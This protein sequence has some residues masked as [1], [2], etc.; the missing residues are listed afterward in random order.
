MLTTSH[1]PGG[2]EHSQGFQVG[3]SW[4][5]R[6]DLASQYIH[7]RQIIEITNT[8]SPPHLTTSSVKSW[9]QIL[10]ALSSRELA[11]ESA[12]RSSV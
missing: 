2:S 8:S 10:Q 11:R 5:S 6:S 4:P 1:M 9:W 7:A 3:I 12:A